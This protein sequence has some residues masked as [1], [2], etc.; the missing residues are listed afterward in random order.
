MRNRASF[1]VAIVVMLMASGP[2]GLTKE[3]AGPDE[4]I[5][6]QAR[7]E[8]LCRQ[9]QPVAAA[10]SGFPE[11]EPVP[12]VV[13]SRAEM[14]HYLLEVLDREYPVRELQRRSNCFAEIGLVPRGYDL[15]EG[16]VAAVD[17]EAG[18]LYDPHSKVFISISDLPDELKSAPYQRLIA[19]HEL[20]HALQDRR[21]DLASRGLE[22]L[23]GLHARGSYEVR[24]VGNRVGFVTGI[25]DLSERSAYLDALLER[26]EPGG[27]SDVSS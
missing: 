26:P 25:S 18:G 4:S 1:L 7:V 16:L 14:R 23:E 12:V 13:L 19:G 15:A 17:Q 22:V 27:E 24:T 8:A 11:G 5:S 6:E 20:T 2:V 10:L 3:N 21:V 9:V